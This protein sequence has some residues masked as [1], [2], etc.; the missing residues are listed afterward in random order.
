MV[1]VRDTITLEGG[2]VKDGKWYYEADG[3]KVELKVVMIDDMLPGI[4]KKCLS[5][6]KKRYVKFADLEDISDF[7]AD[8]KGNNVTVSYLA[9]KVNDNYIPFGTIYVIS[10]QEMEP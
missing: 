9:T 6:D 3:E 4:Y 5:Y 10:C 2:A 8:E 1:A 7:L